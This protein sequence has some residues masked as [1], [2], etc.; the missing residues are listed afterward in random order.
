MK[1]LENVIIEAEQKRDALKQA[2]EKGDKDAETMAI[3]EL[4]ESLQKA[5]VIKRKI[6][7]VISPEPISA[8]YTF[9]DEKGKEKSETIEIDFEK[10]LESFESFYEKHKI[11]L[12]LDFSEKM[13]DIWERNREEIRKAIEENGFD[14]VILIPENLPNLTQINQKM[15]EGY[16][17]TWQSD[18]FKAG[19]SFEGVTDKE[20]GA[21]IILAHSTQHM[22]EHSILKETLGNKAEDLAKKGETLTLTDYLIL[23]RKIFDETGNH[24][25]TK[26]ADGYCYWTWLPGST[27]K[28]SSGVIRFVYANWNPDNGRLN[29]NANDPGDSLPYL[30]CRL[31]RCFT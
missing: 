12:P 10:Q 1:E 11:G 3:K 28:N 5:R 31:S 25:D 6:E 18:N 23:Q 26:H 15:S 19:G 20:S 2:V 8:I 22:K 4:N 30:G 27:V 29:V 21:R 7:G 24:I 16:T 14:T 17:E 13:V 9:K